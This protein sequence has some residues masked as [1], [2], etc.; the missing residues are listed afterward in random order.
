MSALPDIVDVKA[1]VTAGGIVGGKT[2]ATIRRR[3]ELGL[4]CWP[5]KLDQDIGTHWF[6]IFRMARHMRILWM[7]LPITCVASF[8]RLAVLAKHLKAAFGDLPNV[9]LVVNYPRREQVTSS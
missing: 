1:I 2:G 6:L 8:V 5:K 4:T 9:E 7:L 3:D